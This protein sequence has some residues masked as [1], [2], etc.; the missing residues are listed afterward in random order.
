MPPRRGNRVWIYRGKG[1]PDDVRRDYS[2][3]PGPG[4]EESERKMQEMSKEH[5]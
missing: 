5:S 1:D 4:Q 2:I 3:R